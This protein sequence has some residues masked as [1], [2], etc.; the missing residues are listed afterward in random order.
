MDLAKT[1]IRQTPSSGGSQLVTVTYIV[2]RVD[3]FIHHVP[4]V[5]HTGLW[6]ICMTVR[7]I[8]QLFKRL[9][10][11]QWFK[12]LKQIYNIT[13]RARYRVQIWVFGVQIYSDITRFNN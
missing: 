13:L 4:D 7:R 5:S 1:I 3:D 2:A 11:Q 8:N 9:Y 6:N 10:S 12:V